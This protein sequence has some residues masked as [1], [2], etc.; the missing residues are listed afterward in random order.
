MA[1]FYGL[2]ESE[3][4]V[5]SQ[6]PGRIENMEQAGN[7]FDEIEKELDSIDTGGFFSKYKRWSKNR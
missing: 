2:A 3:K 5:L 6:Y 4:E 7:A 1:V